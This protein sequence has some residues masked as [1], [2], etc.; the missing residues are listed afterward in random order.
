MACDWRLSGGSEGLGQG[1]TPGHPHSPVSLQPPQVVRGPLCLAST[2]AP[3]SRVR[4]K[5]P[6]QLLPAFPQPPCGLVHV[7]E[8]PP[9]AQPLLC[10]PSG[11]HATAAAVVPKHAVTWQATVTKVKG[12][13]RWG[14][15]QIMHCS[16][17][18]LFFI[19]TTRGQI[20]QEYRKIKKV[21]L[22]PLVG[23]GW[24]GIR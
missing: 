16:L 15:L 11:G 17:F 9:L 23:L 5:V 20:L 4:G 14:I 7:P 8:S 6:C 24:G 10:T 3:A 12:S 1:S 21:S 13:L 18:L 22:H 19:Q 2:W